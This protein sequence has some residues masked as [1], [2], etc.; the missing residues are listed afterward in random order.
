MLMISQP[1]RVFVKLMASFL[2]SW[3][4]PYND[5]QKLRV[6]VRLTSLW[7]RTAYTCF[8]RRKEGNEGLFL[9]HN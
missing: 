9:E 1:Y 8:R 6:V 4:A 2:F 3:R 5:L 7:D